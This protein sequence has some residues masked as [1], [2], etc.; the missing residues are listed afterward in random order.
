M[1]GL[2]L[3]WSW[4][5]LVRGRT[6]TA[7]VRVTMAIAWALQ[8][9]GIGLATHVPATGAT[10]VFEAYHEVADLSPA[11][12][13]NEEV[14]YTIAHG[15]ALAGQ[16]SA[17]IIKSHGLAKA[18]NSVVDSVTLGNT[19]GFV[20]IVLDDPEGRHSDTILDLRALLQGTGIPF[21]IAESQRIYDDI[22]EAFLWSE[23]I[24]SPVA[25]LVDANI[26]SLETTFQRKRLRPCKAEYRRD[27]WRHVLCPPLAGY[28]YNV[29]QSR[30]ARQDWREIP[31]PE[32][33]AI[34]A[35]LPP[36]WRTEAERFV[37]VFNI[38]Q[39]MRSSIPVVCGDTGLSSMFAFP[40]FSCVDTCSYYGGSLP[41]AIGMHLGGLSRPW[42]VTGD[43]AFVAAGHMGLIEALARGVPLKVMIM[44][45]GHA[46]ATG[47]QPIPPEVYDQLL[48][49]WNP[50]VT[51]IMDPE[52]TSAVRSVLARTMETSRIEIV[53][54]RFRS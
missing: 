50:Y 48:A 54:I 11:F 3:P 13:F 7:T 18:A 24:A 4:P 19:A 52:D 17:A 39:E 12:S 36:Q 15:A 47:G 27:P 30:L 32:M 8:D 38:F 16:R 37:P 31:R 34:P 45:N 14:A 41:M 10:A 26:L 40:P 25:V 46:M 6:G 22:L 43:Y 28:Q 5:G 9:A 20:T 21:K 23:A 44:D 53:S 33:P 1:G 29:L 35:G 51:R 2:V 49:G 42:A